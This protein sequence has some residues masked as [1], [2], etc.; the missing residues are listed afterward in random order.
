MYFPPLKVVSRI[1]GTAVAEEV[2]TLP[3]IALEALLRHAFSGDGFDA[4]YYRNTYQDVATAIADG[5]VPDE[6]THF[7]RYGYFEDRKPRNFDV[8]T[9]WYEDTYQDVSSAIRA[10]TVLD[11]RTHFN[12]VGYFEPRAPT[13]DAAASYAAIFA[14]ATGRLP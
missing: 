7:V 12:R 10:G 6:I 11:A 3:R 8:D 1:P 9:R 5:V 14:G 2:V 4:D 13:K